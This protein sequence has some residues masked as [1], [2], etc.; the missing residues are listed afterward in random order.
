MSFV[1]IMELDIHWTLVAYIWLENDSTTDI[2]VPAS[3]P[4]LV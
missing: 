4:Q 1:W 3:A 2:L